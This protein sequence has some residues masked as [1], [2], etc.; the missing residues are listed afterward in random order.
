[1]GQI[2]NNGVILT[3]LPLIPSVVAIMMLIVKKPDEIVD[4]SKKTPSIN[5]QLCASC[6]VSFLGFLLTNSLIP[7]IKASFPEESH[8]QSFFHIHHF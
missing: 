1:M 4:P 5:Y 7:K 2:T 6:I 3:F 8:I